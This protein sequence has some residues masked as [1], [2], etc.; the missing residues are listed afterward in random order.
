MVSGS[1]H[2][3]VQQLFWTYSFWKK[4]LCYYVFQAAGQ[5]FYVFIT[6]TFKVKSDAHM[7]FMNLVKLK[8]LN[9]YLLRVVWKMMFTFTM[10]QYVDKQWY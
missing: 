5:Q 10:V 4:K 2:S 8:T 3:P 6:H 9:L 7:Y 1:T